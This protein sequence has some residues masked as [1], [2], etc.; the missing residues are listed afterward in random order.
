MK[1][2]LE[3]AKNEHVKIL[4]E[5]SSFKEQVKN[6]SGF[7]KEYTTNL[8]LVGNAG[9]SAIELQEYV[10]FV[11]NLR[12]GKERLEQQVE[13]LQEKTRELEKDVTEHECREQALQKRLDKANAIIA[14]E[15]EHR[16]RIELENLSSRKQDSDG[17]KTGSDG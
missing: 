14:K 10:A 4:K 3:N 8:A 7:E 5:A 1:A 6:L 15:E 2:R 11:A 9:M 13:S 16:E 17:W 12:V